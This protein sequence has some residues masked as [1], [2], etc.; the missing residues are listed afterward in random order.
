MYILK[1][2]T[3]T[4]VRMSAQIDLIRLVRKYL[5]SELNLHL[6]VKFVSCS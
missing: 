6:L 3:A 4:T 5:K 2:I 1:L